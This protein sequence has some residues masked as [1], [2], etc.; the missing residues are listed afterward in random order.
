MVR[1]E[2]G[3]DWWHGLPLTFACL[4]SFRPW[5]LYVRLWPAFLLRR[6]RASRRT[7]LIG[8]LCE[9][10]YRWQGKCQRYHCNCSSFHLCSFRL[11]LVVRCIHS[12]QT[13]RN[14]K[15]VFGDHEKLLRNCKSCRFLG[16]DQ[17]A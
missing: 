7:R 13:A 3:H 16:G 6:A 10:S 9:G 14:V 8:L 17:L 11:M 15:L 5:T 12:H 4:S 2:R 1:V